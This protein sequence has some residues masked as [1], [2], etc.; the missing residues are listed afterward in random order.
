M[1]LPQA[2]G[3][4][5]MQDARMHVSR[6]AYPPSTVYKIQDHPCIRC[7]LSVLPASS[8]ESGSDY[9]FCV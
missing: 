7:P 4:R 3:E 8:T 9:P 5:D 1:G 2:E 6:I